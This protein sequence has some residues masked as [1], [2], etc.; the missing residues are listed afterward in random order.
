[1][2][3]RGSGRAGNLRIPSRSTSIT[4][5]CHWTSNLGV[6]QVPAAHLNTTTSQIIRAESLLRHSS[7]RDFV[8]SSALASSCAKPTEEVAKLS[9]ALRDRALRAVVIV[10]ITLGATAIIVQL[11]KG[12]D[13]VDFLVYRQASRMALHGADVYSQN[14]SGPMIKGPGLPYTYTPFGL[15]ALLPTILFRWHVAYLAWC[16]ADM[17]AIALILNAVVAREVAI[18]RGARRAIILAVALALTAFSTIVINEVSFGQING[19]LLGASLADVLRSREGRLARFLPP[20]SLIGIATAIKLLSGLLICYFILT[21]QWR[22]ARNSIVTCAVCTLI[23]GLAYP[24]MTVRFFSTVVWQLPQRVAIG[25]FATWGNNSVQGILAALGVQPGLWR[26]AASAAVAAGGLW[27]AWA[28]HRRGRELEAWLTVGIVA[29][30]A[31]PVS[32]IHHWVWLAPAVLLVAL[33]T[34]SYLTWT[35]TGLVTAVMLIGG[36]EP[37][38]QLVTHGPAWALPVGALLRESLV[39]TGIWCIAMFLAPASRASAPS[40]T[41][42]S[43]PSEA[44]AD[45]DAKRLGDAAKEPVPGTTAPTSTP[46]RQDPREPALQLPESPGTP[47]SSPASGRDAASIPRGG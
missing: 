1:M 7:F 6:A 21:R 14:I 19:L 10:V 31:S 40:E 3:T 44:L 42:R 4:R 39:A 33:R 15:I 35:A 29:Q 20:G 13:P 22:L 45:R 27:A 30:L 34:R 8:Q 25:S 43:D 17:L 38:G 12:V 23:G 18:G 46:S 26:T 9:A 28:C 36:P 2:T 11:V 16:L 47:S 24:G 32:W 5:C 41:A 37:G